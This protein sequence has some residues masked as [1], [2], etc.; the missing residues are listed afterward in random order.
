MES[1]FNP[2][3]INDKAKIASYGFGQLTLA[4]AKAHCNLEKK[5]IFDQ[6]KNGECAAKVF[7]N[8]YKRFNKSLL[9]TILAYNEGTPC[10]CDGRFYTRDLGRKKLLCRSYTKT[11]DKWESVALSCSRKNEVRITNYYK[12]FKKHY[13]IVSNP[14]I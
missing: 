9:L 6:R 12:D 8:Q 5:D 1:C 11:G 13:K 4:T 7:A 3:A 2:K 10:I 14:D